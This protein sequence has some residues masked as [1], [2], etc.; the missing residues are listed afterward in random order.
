VSPMR[1]F[2]PA[3]E[4]TTL[5]FEPL[6]EPPPDPPPDPP[7][8]PPPEPLPEP[9]DEPFFPLL[10]APQ[11][12]EKII[13]RDAQRISSVRVGLNECIVRRFVISVFN[14]RPAIA[15]TPP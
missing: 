3:G 5:E 11:P 14:F 12:I 10:A 9:P 4:I 6:P 7:P 8:E 15:S 2:A 1:T 13:A